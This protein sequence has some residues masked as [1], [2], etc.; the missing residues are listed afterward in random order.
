MVSEQT[1]PFEMCHK[2][3]S[4]ETKNIKSAPYKSK[5]SAWQTNKQTKTTISTKTHNKL[6][7]R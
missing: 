1:K 6:I 3:Q 5:L 2:I 4:H 7:K